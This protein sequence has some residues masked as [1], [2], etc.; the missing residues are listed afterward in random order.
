MAGAG[1]PDLTWDETATAVTV[2]YLTGGV[3]LTLALERRGRWQMCRV[4][5][6]P[7]GFVAWL[8]FSLHL[9]CRPLDPIRHLARLVSRRTNA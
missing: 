9:W 6:C 7:T 1:G 2:G 5:R 3:L 4:L 8:I